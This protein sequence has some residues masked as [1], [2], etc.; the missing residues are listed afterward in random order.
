[1]LDIVRSA[2]FDPEHASEIAKFAVWA[3]QTLVMSEPGFGP[4]LSA[5]ERAEGQ[6]RKQVELA[7]LSPDHYP[8]IV[9]AAVAMTSCEN[10]EF[11]YRFGVDLFIAGV[12]AL[13]P[14]R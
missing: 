13:A 2:G 5:Q 7:S 8:R 10:A 12:R 6:R 9:E 14:S 11:H 4:A 1:M 3:G